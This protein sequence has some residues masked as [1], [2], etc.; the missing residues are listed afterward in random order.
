MNKKELRQL[1]LDGIVERVT[2][3]DNRI[4]AEWLEDRIIPL[5]NRNK[6]LSNLN[7]KYRAE[8]GISNNPIE[9]EDI[10]I[11]PIENS[12]TVE[13]VLTKENCPHP[14]H[15]VKEHIS[16]GRFDECLDCGKTW[17]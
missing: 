10:E 5:E 15:R 16:G 7:F 11:K 6:I 4:Y 12:I 2:S 3:N 17:G 1:W 14:S 9:I 8:L 13:K